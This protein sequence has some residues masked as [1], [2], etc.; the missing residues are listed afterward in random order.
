MFINKLFDFNAFFK[1]I[2]IQDFWGKNNSAEHT[3]LVFGKS[4]RLYEME[5]SLAEYAAYTLSW[6][7]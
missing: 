1:E 3:Q 2:T 4:P 5:R 6:K 7:I